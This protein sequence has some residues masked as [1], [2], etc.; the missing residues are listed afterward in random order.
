ML[1]MTG[2]Y[3]GQAIR[4]HSL[5]RLETLRQLFWMSSFITRPLDVSVRFYPLSNGWS[6]SGLDPALP[7][8][9][10]HRIEVCEEHKLLRFG[11]GYT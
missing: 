11:I 2:A 5:G 3:L 4:V 6:I 10:W 7:V 9:H 8:R 1:L